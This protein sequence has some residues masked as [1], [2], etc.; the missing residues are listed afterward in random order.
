MRAR[1]VWSGLVASVMLVVTVLPTLACT[2]IT[3][4]AADGSVV[5]GRTME[6]GEP[7][8]SDV[9]LIPRGI[10]LAGTTTD[11][12]DS[13]LQ[14]TAKHAAAGVNGAGLPIII[15]GLNE[16]G[17]GA[18]TFYFPGFADYQQIAADERALVL[19][20]WQVVTWALTNF[21][22][23]AEVRA[24]LPGVRVGNVV[25][26]AWNIVPPFHYV[27][28][29]A[30]GA[31][32][33]VEYVAGELAIFDNALGVLTNSPPFD[34]HMTNLR[35]YIGI[36]PDPQQGVRLDGIDLDPLSNGGNLFGMPGD[37][38]SPSR[39]VR[40]VVFT[41]MTPPAA[42]GQDA[43]RQGFHILDNFDIPEGAVPEPAGSEPPYEITE[44]TTM[45]NLTGRIFAIW[46]SDNRDI[47][48][49]DLNTIDLD[50]SAIRT[51]SLDQEQRF[52]DLGAA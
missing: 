21:A 18:G 52:I 39:F 42:T 22:T 7:L 36:T 47:R 33:T 44:W 17:L 3:L 40:A 30:T 26:A 8:E 48:T 41:Q 23:V 25:F 4:I 9:I 38:S 27:F 35:N 2:G 20:P 13:G 31:T 51:F 15:D 49:L 1:V 34:W 32:M 10:A 43:M 46:T 6:F 24:A 11:G 37:F 19:A 16:H 29:D 12:T 14:W 28:T 45:S 50:G 5:R